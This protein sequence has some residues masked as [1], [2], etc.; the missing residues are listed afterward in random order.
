MK[1]EEV[2]VQT[3][4]EQLTTAVTSLEDAVGRRL[5]DQ[6]D[7][8]QSGEEL[9]TMLSDRMRLANELDQTQHRA[10][11]LEEANREVSRRLVASMET[12]RA[13]LDRG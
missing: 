9:Q 12:I 11:K 7:A 1:L 13:V 8:V 6:K 10:S 5:E 4:L 2:T 3:A